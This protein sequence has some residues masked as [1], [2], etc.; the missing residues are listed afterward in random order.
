MDQ[1]CASGEVAWLGAGALGRG[2]GRVALYFRE[3]LP[4]LGPPP[5]RG[6]LPAGEQHEAVRARLTAGACFFTDLLVDVALSPEE[7]QTALWDL[8]W[9]GVATNDAFAPLRAPRL[10]LARAQ[11]ESTRRASRRGGRFGAARRRDAA[12]AQVQGRWSLTEP[13]LRTQTD[14]AAQRR[15]LGELLL[16]RY[17]IVTREQVLAE[18]VPGGFSAIY[19]ELSQLETLGVA[20]RGYFLEGLGGAQFALPGAVERL[21]AR[22]GDQDQAPLVLA[23]VDPAQPY[24]AALPWPKA[25]QPDAA[26]GRRPSRTAGAYVVLADGDPVIY[27]ERGG[28]GLATLVAASDPRLDPA[29]AALVQSVRAGRIKRVALEKVDG[30][31]AMSSPLAPALTAHGFQEGPRRL[32]LSA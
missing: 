5:Y 27:L 15:A 28:R 18:G 24:G 6:E 7:I 4:L 9:A 8:A 21:R 30:Q 11:R 25:H 31:P 1:L 13:L 17:G 22:A 12:S 16:E 2:S 19:S 14:P 20:R 3:D 26:T 32:T 10:T 29:L 23:A